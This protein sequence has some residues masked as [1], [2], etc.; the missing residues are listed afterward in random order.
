[1]CA[2]TQETISGLTKNN[3]CKFKFWRDEGLWVVITGAGDTELIETASQLVIEALRGDYTLGSCWFSKELSHRIQDAVMAF[4]NTSLLPYPK[5]ERPFVDLLIGISIHNERCEYETLF[6]ASGTTVREIDPGEGSLGAECLGLGLILAKSLIERLYGPFLNLDELLLTAAFIIFQAK[7]FVDG[8][9]GE[10]D[11]VI[12]SKHIC[13]TVPRR[14]IAQLEKYFQKFDEWTGD[15]VHQFS[16]IT[17]SDTKIRT[18]LRRRQKYILELR[19]ELF[20]ADLDVFKI[21]KEIK[22][23]RERP[24]TTS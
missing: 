13:R 7:R 10:T 5:D 14:D 3:V 17:I 16:N 12:L 19:Q 8:C 2:D 24:S 21:L 1:M 22:E 9:G 15:L 6:K 23:H 18:E 20:K 11:L 4:F